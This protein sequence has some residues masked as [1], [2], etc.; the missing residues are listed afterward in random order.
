MYKI[1]IH[2]SNDIIVMNNDNNDNNNHQHHNNFSSNSNRIDNRCDN[3]KNN[4]K[5]NIKNSNIVI[6]ISNSRNYPT[7]TNINDDTNNTNNQQQ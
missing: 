7:R 3:S 6:V 1:S 2:D 5:W 4:M